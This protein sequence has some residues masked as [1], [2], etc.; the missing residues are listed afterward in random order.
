MNNNL[1]VITEVGYKDIVM[2]GFTSKD[3]HGFPSTTH[4]NGKHGD[5]RYLRTDKTG[6]KLDISKNPTDLD[7]TRKEKRIDAFKKFGWRKFYSVYYKINKKSKL[8]KLSND[9]PPHHHH[10]H[11]RLFKPN[12][13]K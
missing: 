13:K 2:V 3:N 9:M 10:L 7:V 1:N 11:T 8:L 6:G 5:F 12:F 4:I